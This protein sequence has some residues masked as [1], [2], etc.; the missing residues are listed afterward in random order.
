MLVDLAILGVI[1]VIVEAIGIYA[2]NA[3]LTCVMMSTAFSLLIMY[4]ATYRW[5]WKG[6]ILAPILAIATI[7]C[8]RYLNPRLTYRVNY[9]WKLYIA[10]VFQLL[11]VS[12]NILWFKKIKDEYQTTKSIRMT[13][14]LCAIDCLISLLV[15][16]LV[17]FIFAKKFLILSFI[18]WNAFG[19]AILF[20]GAFILGRQNILVNIKKD[21]LRKEEER[22]EAEAE[23]S[24]NLSEEEKLDEQKGDYKNG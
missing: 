5:G 17:Y 15:L 4:A 6:L 21:L 13:F 10:T 19:Y 12:F 16:S 23:F 1:G 8:G 24:L 18:I 20:V 9:D 11:S 3:M 14:G 7:L 22:K 2:F